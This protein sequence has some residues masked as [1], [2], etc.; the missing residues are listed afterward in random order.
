ML[1]LIHAFMSG[2]QMQSLVRR[3]REREEGQTFVEYALVIGAVSIALLGAF[4]LLDDALAGVVND[5]TNAL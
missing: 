5:I 3:V 1:N 2:T 4:A